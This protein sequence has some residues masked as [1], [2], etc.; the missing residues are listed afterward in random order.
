MFH[1]DKSV[2]SNELHCEMACIQP[3]GA[4]GKRCA[5]APDD[6]VERREFEEGLQC[7]RWLLG[8]KEDLAEEY[9]GDFA[10]RYSYC[11]LPTMTDCS[12]GAR[13]E[14]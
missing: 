9:T 14:K 4:V 7:V 1:L 13:G 6:R 12:Q 5:N 8:G 11:M 2:C 10:S 3:Y